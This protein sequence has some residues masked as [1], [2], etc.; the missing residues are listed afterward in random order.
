[1]NCEYA[2]CNRGEFRHYATHSVDVCGD[3]C[4]ICDRGL[5]MLRE[6]APDR[7]ATARSLNPYKTR[8]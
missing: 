6:A 5:E 8:R 1:M 4:Y 3:T 7:A 2:P